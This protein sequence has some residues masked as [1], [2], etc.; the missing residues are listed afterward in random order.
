M[1]IANRNTFLI[2]PQG[3]ITQEWT[4]VNPQ[5]AASDVLAA[6]PAS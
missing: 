5:T 1:T 4:K 3:K 2:D 6:I